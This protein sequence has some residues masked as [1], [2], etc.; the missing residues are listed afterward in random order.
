M[1]VSL[2]WQACLG[3]TMNIA[4]WVVVP[5]GATIISIVLSLPLIGPLFLRSLQSQDMYLA[6]AIILIL[7]TLTVIGVL[8]SDEHDDVATQARF[9]RCFG[10]RRSI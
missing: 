3:V 10:R 5:G 9:Q 8:I 6:G 1:I 4:S 7:S 2:S